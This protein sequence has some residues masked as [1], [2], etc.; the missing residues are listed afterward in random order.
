M[1]IV[2]W[3]SKSRTSG[4]SWHSVFTAYERLEMISISL[5]VERVLTAAVG[6]ALLLNGGGL[7]AVS[8]VFTA[9]SFVGLLTATHGLRRY[10]VSPRWEIDRSRWLPLLKAGS[11][12]VW[13]ASYSRSCCASTHRC[14]ASWTTTSEVGIYGAAF[15]VIE[16]TLF[17]PVGAQQRV[18][19]LALH[20]VRR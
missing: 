6:I 20:A 1:Y 8:I 11:R 17:I 4:R 2:G 5:V 12:S 19:S 9:G 10:M 13:T 14:S 15:R 3:E 7:V 16:A 18:A